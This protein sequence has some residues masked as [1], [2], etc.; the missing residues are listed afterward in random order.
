MTGY[1]IASM[2]ICGDPKYTG[3]RHWLSASN[4]IWECV[5]EIPPTW[6]NLLTDDLGNPFPSHYDG[7]QMLDPHLLGLIDSAGLF[8]C[9]RSVRLPNAALEGLNPDPKVYQAIERELFHVGW[10]ICSGNGWLSASC[11]G[12]FPVNPF[13]GEVINKGDLLINRFGLIDEYAHCEIYCELNNT[14]I[15]EHA[16]WFPVR[17]Y[18]SKIGAER[19]RTL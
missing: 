16:P 2:M 9:F 6:Q 11:H 17:V 10:D 15:A 5:T 8:A 3:G 7:L 19:L 18:I 4:S 1:S 13:T 12:I 14:A